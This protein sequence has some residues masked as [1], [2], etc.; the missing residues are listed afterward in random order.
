MTHEVDCFSL[1][2]TYVV[3]G[4]DGS[5]IPVAVSDRFFEALEHKFGDFKGKRLLS[6]FTFHQDWDTWEMHPAGDEFVCLLSGQVDLILEQV[7]AEK[8]VRLSTPGSYTLIP[9]GIWHTAKV[10]TPCSML[11]I[12]PGEGTQNRPL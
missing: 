12:T 9:Q 3:L 7:G 4:D 8:T 10:H 2:S 1:S 11:F 5:A 6:H